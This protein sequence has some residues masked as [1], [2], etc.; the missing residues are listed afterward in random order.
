M[1]LENEESAFVLIGGLAE[2]DKG[3]VIAKM[4]E[5]LVY[6]SANDAISSASLRNEE[7]VTPLIFF[8]RDPVQ[9]MGSIQA[10]FEQ[11][12]QQF[13][14][15]LNDS[16]RSFYIY[17]ASI[18]FCL[19]CLRFVLNLST[20]PLAN[21]FLGALCFGGVLKVGSLF[22]QDMVRSLLLSVWI[23]EIP[24]SM[25]EPALFCALGFLLIVAAFIAFLIKKRRRVDEDF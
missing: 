20:W 4:G 25:L 8:R 6:E 5:A 12:G 11:V 21:F 7:A 24:V 1:E 2:P 9:L 3:R 22:E 14:T 18:I 10:A 23:D 19:S 16:R 17:A 13:N 15:R